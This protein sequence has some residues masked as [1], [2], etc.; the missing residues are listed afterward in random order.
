MILSIFR[1]FIEILDIMTRQINSMSMMSI[2]QTGRS[3]FTA[4]DFRQSKT[5]EITHD[6]EATDDRVGLE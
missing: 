5:Q 6:F 1:Y 2:Q 4:V 3:D